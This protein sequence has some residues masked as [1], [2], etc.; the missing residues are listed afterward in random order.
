MVR[1]SSSSRFWKTPPDRA[2]V[3]RPV[4]SRSRAH[5]RAVA[6][7]SPLWKRAETSAGTAP[8]RVSSTT[9][10]TRSAARIVTSGPSSTI[11]AW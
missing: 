3:P 2:T 11:R 5:T 6:T 8:A 1:P 4:S 9:A 7:A 10:R